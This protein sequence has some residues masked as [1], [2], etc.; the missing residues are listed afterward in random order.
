MLDPE[1]YRLVGTEVF[2]CESTTFRDDER[3]RYLEHDYFAFYDIEYKIYEYQAQGYIVE[4][5]NMT[6][7]MV[8]SSE[9]SVT[10]V[11]SINLVLYMDND[12]YTQT[13]LADRQKRERKDK[14]NKKL[15]EQKIRNAVKNLY[16]K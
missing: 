3:A 10:L 6:T 5:G 4:I 1:R 9:F 12:I 8:E 14:L 13:I 2:T 16:N 7:T 11:H 15:E